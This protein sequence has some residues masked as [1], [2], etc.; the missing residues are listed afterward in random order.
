M[1]VGDSN[2]YLLV[3]LPESED[4]IPPWGD[5]QPTPSVG[6]ATSDRLLGRASRM[7]TGFADGMDDDTATGIEDTFSFKKM[8]DA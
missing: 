8:S 7:D 3:A 5:A 1:L 4:A 6:T 2:Q